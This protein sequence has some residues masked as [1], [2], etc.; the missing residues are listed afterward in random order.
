MNIYQNKTHVKEIMV[1][2]ILQSDFGERR[3]LLWQHKDQVIKNDS[4]SHPT[5]TC[6]GIYAGGSRSQVAKVLNKL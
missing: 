5:Q 1:C 6:T 4:C 3:E 2:L